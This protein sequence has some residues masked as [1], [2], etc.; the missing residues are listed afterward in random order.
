MK[1]LI[2]RM[3][4]HEKFVTALS[5]TDYNIKF[6]SSERRS[7]ETGIIN[8]FYTQTNEAVI[9]PKIINDI[10]LRCRYLSSI[11]YYDASRYVRKM[12]LCIEDYLKNNKYDLIL[13][14]P[15]DN[16]VADIL[17][18]IASNLKIP[19]FYFAFYP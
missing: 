8:E 13:T 17:F 7:D 2:Y 14:P 6:I 1:I 5:H 3:F 11:N 9:D 19:C 12:W 4:F 15:V 16:Y 10:V 18:K